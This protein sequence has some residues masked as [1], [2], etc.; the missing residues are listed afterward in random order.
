MTSTGE[1]Y[2][3]E[4]HARLINKFVIL[5]KKLKKGQKKFV[6]CRQK[7]KFIL[8]SSNQTVKQGSWKISK[9]Q[10]LEEATDWRTLLPGLKN[11]DEKL[12]FKLPTSYLTF[13]Y[14]FTK[15]VLLKE[16]RD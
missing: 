7:K 1:N 16:P 15:Y 14:S 8:D 13:N 10:L 2:L 9:G 11:S 5:F 6:G 12:F 4:G 3:I